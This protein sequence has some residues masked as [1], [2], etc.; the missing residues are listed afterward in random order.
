MRWVH[1]VFVRRLLLFSILL[2]V[3]VWV[4]AGAD[5][6]R[7]HRDRRTAASEQ[8][9]QL[10]VALGNQVGSLLQ[11]ADMALLG[12]AKGLKRAHLT[13]RDRDVQEI[14]LQA[15]SRLGDLF[16]IALFDAGGR[17]VASSE[18]GF[19]PG[20][21]FSDR[22]YVRVHL[23]GE[24]EG[25]FVDGPLFGRTFGKHFL[26]LSRAVHAA[27]GQLI[28][29]LMASVDA[30]VIGLD[31]SHF[32]LGPNGAIALLHA[33]GKVVARWPNF[34]QHF[35]QDVS[36][37]RLFTELLARAGE[38]EYEVATST[39]GAVRRIHY[40]RVGKTPLI[41]AVGYAPADIWS[42]VCSGLA[43]QLA[44]AV[45]GSLVIV[46]GAAIL[47]RGERRKLAAVDGLMASERRYRGL[48][49]SVRDGIVMCDAEGRI[50][51]CNEAFGALL[52]A[53]RASLMG[54]GLYELLAAGDSRETARAAFS[55]IDERGHCDE[56][57][58]EFFRGAG[59]RVFVRIRGWLNRGAEGETL[60][61]WMIVRDVTDQKQAEE[62][63]LLAQRI[64]ENSS[65]AI[66]VADARTRIVAVNAAFEKISGYATG[67]ILGRTTNLLK[68]GWHDATF[69]ARMWSVLEGNGTW[70]GEI[71][72]R[73]KSGETFPAWVR[74]STIRDPGDGRIT[75]FVAVLS[76]VSERKAAEERIRFLA[77]HDALTG[78][79]NRNSLNDFLTGALQE[80][81]E[82]GGRMA[83]MFIDLDNF[84]TINDS[85]GHQTG[86]RL[87]I[88]VARRMRRLVRLS[89]MVARLGGDEFVV[90]MQG[91]RGVEAVSETAMKII[92]R[93]GDAYEIDGHRL[94]TSPSIGISL[95]PDDGDTMEILMRH[96]DTA[97][98]HAKAA[99][100][101]TARFFTP[102]M[103]VAANQRLVL[104]NALR[105]AIDA[106]QMSLYFQPQVDLEGG[107]ERI[108]GVEA[109]V[110]WQ[111]PELG[112]ISPV[113][114]I[115]VAEES[116]LILQI[117]EWVLRHA[118]G[119]AQQWADAGWA[120]G[121]LA[122][123]ISAR[124]F[125]DPSF[126]ETV[127][128]VLE[129]TGWPPAR[130]ELEITETAV[131]DAPDSTAETMRRLRSMGIRLAIDDFG[132]GYSSLS[133]LHRFPVTRLKIDQV[134]V[135]GVSEDAAARTLVS[136]IVALG[137]A[138]DLE[139]LAEG[140]ETPE[141]AA[142]VRSLGCR[143]AQGYLFHRPLPDRAVE[144]LLCPVTAPG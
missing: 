88:E 62:Q 83:L 12:I 92:R 76:D 139:L 30:R 128:A 2:L 50:L 69:Y 11:A 19:T 117:G 32:Q 5:V 96:A 114:F 135:G 55:Q 109:L 51:D 63:L 10:A 68:S 82:S 24:V 103:N 74:I 79:P 26:P 118:C 99:G 49:D 54:R 16:S 141:Q 40:R 97:M 80:S 89:D 95:F 31:F 112:P 18:P 47:W 125:R 78:L 119:Q 104:E 123:N 87:L 39:D 110:R 21:D 86:D 67:E 44:I 36:R 17:S 14:L 6:W 93:L 113:D 131:M 4:T 20:R 132:T 1:D 94:H 90:V 137:Q 138:L 100:R 28:G 136:A 85:L 84:K 121:L 105:G 111:H 57:E 58:T 91:V 129:Q 45:L 41:M 126:C 122:V 23:N 142:F 59:E 33:D 53:R 70:E 38:G 52:K 37:S 22:T 56:F 27:D 130:L 46:S 144:A 34:D 134:F 43:A 61:R 77:H 98:Y 29:V 101:N 9:R 42:E 65:E 133:Y 102:P 107:G 75:H 143:L 73:R 66:V 124:Q 64:I 106:G 7:L 25:L 115:P 140:V 13:G 48:Y 120:D 15:D 35:G 108:V 8:T 127:G 71:T 116:G 72:E 60:N 81:G 3:L